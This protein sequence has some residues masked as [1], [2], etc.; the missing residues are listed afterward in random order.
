M[1]RIAVD[2]AT[3]LVLLL[4]I[5]CLFSLYE[6]LLLVLVVVVVV[7]VVGFIRVVLL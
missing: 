3:S 2:K 6:V 5:G 7:V 4:K 1:T